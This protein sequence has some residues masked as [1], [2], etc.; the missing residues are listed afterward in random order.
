VYFDIEADK[1]KRQAIKDERNKLMKM[2]LA[3]K[4]GG[5]KTRPPKQKDKINFECE[6]IN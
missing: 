2:M 6:T 1:A 4:E 3:E 5:G